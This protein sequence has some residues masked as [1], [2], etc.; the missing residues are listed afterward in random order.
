MH[1]D[2]FNRLLEANGRIYSNRPMALTFAVLYIVGIAMSSIVLSLAVVGAAHIMSDPDY[3]ARLA[4][5]PWLG[6]AMFTAVELFSL[7]M[8]ASY[9]I[10]LGSLILAVYQWALKKGSSRRLHEA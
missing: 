5:T 3:P 1:P 9:L 8:R 4:E 7:G 2:W 10:I 6:W